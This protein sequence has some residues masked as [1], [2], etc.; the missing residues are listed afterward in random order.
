MFPE[1]ARYQF[2]S[3]KR[4]VSGPSPSPTLRGPSSFLGKVSD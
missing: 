1:H 4:G 3:Q 2:G